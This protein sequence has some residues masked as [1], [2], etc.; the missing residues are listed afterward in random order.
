MD[1]SSAVD[2][3]VLFLLCSNLDGVASKFLSWSSG[4]GTLGILSIV[5]S[6]LS[7]NWS[8]LSA[9]LLIDIKLFLY[10]HPVDSSSHNADAT[11]TLKLFAPIYHQEGAATSCAR[12]LKLHCGGFINRLPQ[13]LIHT[14]DRNRTFC[15]G[16]KTRKRKITHVVPYPCKRGP[17]T[18]GIS[19]QPPLWAQFPAKV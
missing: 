12:N 8:L 15:H 4:N 14:R 16:S 10:T 17:T 11:L 18:Y 2:D 7:R 1:C 13:R 19:A 3:W 9:K 6:H 5:A